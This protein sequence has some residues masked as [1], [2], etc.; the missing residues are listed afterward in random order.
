MRVTKGSETPDL[1]Q[2]PRPDYID[3]VY[4]ELKAPNRSN[5]CRNVSFSRADSGDGRSLTW[6]PVSWSELPQLLLPALVD[7]LLAVFTAFQKS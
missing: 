7:C 2:N 3:A 5:S 4:V 6:I 1:V